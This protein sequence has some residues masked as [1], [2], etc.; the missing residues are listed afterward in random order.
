VEGYP[1]ASPAGFRRGLRGD[2]DGPARVGWSPRQRERIWRQG[3]PAIGDDRPRDPGHGSELWVRAEE[4]EAFYFSFE[5]DRGSGFFLHRGDFR[6][7]YRDGPALEIT[8]GS[9][10]LRVEPES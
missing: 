4:D 7:A 9:L 1:P 2:A 8:S 5:E 6:G 10:V 3:Q